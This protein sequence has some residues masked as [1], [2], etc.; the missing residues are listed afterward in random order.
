MNALKIPSFSFGKEVVALVIV[1]YLSLTVPRPWISWPSSQSGLHRAAYENKFRVCPSF[2]FS[3]GLPIAYRR[4][5]RR[6][7]KCVLGLSYGLFSDRNS[8]MLGFP[9]NGKNGG[10]LVAK[11]CPTLRNPMDWSLPGSSVHGI[12]QARTL[13]GGHF[14][15]QWEEWWLLI[16]SSPSCYLLSTIPF[17]QS[18]NWTLPTD[19]ILH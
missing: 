13:V 8:G 16:P 10:G 2:C 11:S 17:K 3:L 19:L 18:H 15:L 1:A 9:Y 6:N 12:L 5:N 14:L 7:Q 4:K